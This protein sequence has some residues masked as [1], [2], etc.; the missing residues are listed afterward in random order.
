MLLATARFVITTIQRIFF[1]LL[2]LF[3]PKGPTLDCAQVVPRALRIVA[4]D[5][6]CAP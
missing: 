5:G 6:V 2:C 4:V 1:L 3:L